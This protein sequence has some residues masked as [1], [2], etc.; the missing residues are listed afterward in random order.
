MGRGKAKAAAEPGTP[1]QGSKTRGGG[2][3]IAGVDCVPT[4][5]GAKSKR[6]RAEVAPPKIAALLAE[7]GGYF[8]AVDE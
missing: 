8:G 2:L 1:T 6:K 4:P 3:A 5:P 7:G